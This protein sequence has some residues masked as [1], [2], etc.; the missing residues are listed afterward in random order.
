MANIARTLALVLIAL[1]AGCSDPA[2]TIEV[3]V[4][5]LRED[6]I[7]LRAA[8]RLPD[9]RAIEPRDVTSRLDRFDWV[10]TAAIAGPL[11]L[12][13]AGVDGAHCQVAAGDAAVLITGPGR[14]TARVRLE[15][16][17]GCRV[18]VARVLG[19]DGDGDGLVWSVPAGISCGARVAVAAC[20]QDPGC[21][22]VCSAA[23]PLNTPV[24]LYTAAA[25]GSYS[26]GWVSP[27][28]GPGPLPLSVTTEG[29]EARVAFYKAQ[30]CYQSGFCWQNPLPDGSSL[31][32]VWAVAA[33]DVWA[34]GAAATLLHYDGIRWG[35]VPITG[36]D[37]G[38][39]LRGIWAS[40]PKDLWLV[41]DQG[42]ILRGDG[43]TFS[44]LAAGT[45][46]GLRAVAGRGAANVW[47]VG[48]EGMMLRWDGARL[49][50]L[51][52]A[53]QST[54]NAVW[55]DET[56]TAW[57]GSD[58]AEIL[59]VAPERGGPDPLALRIT[60]DHLEGDVAIAGLWG[61][62]QEEVWAV[63]QSAVWSWNGSAWLRFPQDLPDDLNLSAVAGAGAQALWL[64]GNGGRLYRRRGAAF[65]A[66]ESD[67]HSDLHG[68]F[69][70]N[71]T[72]FWAVGQTGSIVRWNGQLWT[73]EGGLEERDLLDVSATSA[74]EAWAVGAE[75]ALLSW[76]GVAWNRWA[77]IADNY[78]SVF[79]DGGN[80]MTAV[81]AS[82]VLRITPAAKDP[83]VSY[84]IPGSIEPGRSFFAATGRREGPLT[85]LAGAAISVTDGSASAMVLESDLAER[86]L[87]VAY[88]HPAPADV[89]PPPDSA[90]ERVWIQG[91]EV[92]A[93]GYQSKAAPAGPLDPNPY[94]ALVVRCTRGARGVPFK[95]TELK[96]PRAD[97]V[98]V[99]SDVIGAPSGDRW[100]VGTLI[101]QSEARSYVQR[102]QGEVFS[103]AASGLDLALA[104]RI[105]ST[106][107]GELW[108]SSNRGLSRWDE[109][110]RRWEWAIPER[111][112]SLQ[113]ITSLPEGQMWAVG[114]KGAILYRAAL[115]KA[116][117]QP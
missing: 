67:F 4:D 27:R 21:G 91:D 107:S 1:L 98:Y 3:T 57:A 23:F 80:G 77:T 15:D 86:K 117:V 74:T 92:W 87:Q 79:S 66:Y 114:D 60:I 72:A 102:L 59:R 52:Q 35:R 108:L 12:M 9:G 28:Q 99:V 75:G 105:H 55:V 25:P 5:G 36:L 18:S 45:R 61:R 13:V 34:V 64:V 48:E 29:T 68:V 95:C 32:A 82:N 30:R 10:S 14:Y 101:N 69:G 20:D 43:L 93:V 115:P 70:L 51:V 47:I 56:G 71:E 38:V 73:G 103:D 83:L 81:S 63:G 58:H 85:Y 41:G 11:L 111:A 49:V 104:N 110:Q 19:S 24:T 39:R 89:A 17:P 53:T 2:I 50:T 94:R 96:P 76:S 62:S 40:G 106:A 116:S 88:R 97:E 90:F 42:T 100:L 65:I 46:R 33:D 84:L 37:E 7:S 8:M 16:R 54:L 113:G 6:V 22:S 31:N 109:A 78:T 26:P 112:A 44:P